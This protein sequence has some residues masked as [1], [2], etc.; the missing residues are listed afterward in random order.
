MT[1]VGEVNRIHRM[2]VIAN[3]HEREATDGCSVSGFVRELG[4]DPRFVIVEFNGEALDRKRF[5]VVRLTDGD[6]IE[7]VRAVA[8][9]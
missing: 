5:D 6:R 9:G 1:G 7:I 2:K 8:G 4:L 3:G